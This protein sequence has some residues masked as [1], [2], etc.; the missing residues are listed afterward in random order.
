VFDL[1]ESVSKLSAQAVPFG[2]CLSE[3]GLTIQLALD[4]GQVC[5]SQT[6]GAR[7]RRL[8]GFPLWSS[9]RPGRTRIHTA[10]RLASRR[11]QR[12]ESLS[13]WHAFHVQPATPSSA[14]C[15]HLMSSMVEDA[16]PKTGNGHLA[17][18]SGVSPRSDR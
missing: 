13:F 5:R 6:S 3:F 4:D 7:P 9:H 1:I 10:V 17:I 11:S 18:L 14:R 16:F 15:C 12:H 2:L 8:P